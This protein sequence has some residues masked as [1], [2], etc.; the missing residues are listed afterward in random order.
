MQPKLVQYAAEAQRPLDVVIASEQSLPEGVGAGRVYI[1]VFLDTAEV[2]ALADDHE[3]EIAS[4]S[5]LVADGRACEGYSFGTQSERALEECLGSLP[6]RACLELG[7]S[8]AIL[9]QSCSPFNIDDSLGRHTCCGHGVDSSGVSV[10]LA[11][12]SS[13]SPSS[14]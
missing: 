11:P 2:R 9:L 4:R 10:A 7:C 12:S 14:P 1:N 13:S 3:I 5:S 8:A 6:L